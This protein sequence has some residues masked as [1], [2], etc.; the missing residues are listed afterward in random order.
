MSSR[1][2]SLAE[3]ALHNTASS[4]WV[5]IHNNVYDMTEFLPDHPGGSNIILKYAGRDATAVYDPI[6]PPDALEKNLPPEK[7]LGGID[8]ASAVSLKAAQD[9]K[10]QTKDELR[11]EKAVTEKPAINRML[12]IQ[13]IEDVAMR[14]MSYKTMSYY[15]SGADDELTKRENGKAFSRFFFHPRVMRPISTVDPST[16]ILGFKSTL[17]IFVSAAG[18]AK[19]GHPLGALGVLKK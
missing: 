2:W 14:V 6:H 17:P 4:C 12:S 8:I 10:R 1:I 16:T 15:V 19:L 11:V 3:V 9:S 7:Y 18:L 13:D 5:I